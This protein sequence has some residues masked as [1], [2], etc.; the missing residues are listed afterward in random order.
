MNVFMTAL[1]WECRRILTDPA[2]RLLLIV[3][4]V[5]YGLVYPLP[6]ARQ[7]LRDVPIAVVDLAPGVLGRELV[8]MLDAH[9]L[10]R[11][12]LVTR[13]MT[14]ARRALEDEEVW[15]IVV[16]PRDLDERVARG[17]AVDL[18]TAV[19]ATYFLVYKN[20]ATATVEAVSTLSASVEVRRLAAR[21]VPL[22][23]ARVQA[24]P[25]ALDLRPAFNPVESYSA[26]VV[27]AVVIAILHQL[28]LIGIGVLEGTHAE[29]ARRG[30]RVP[31][32]PVVALCARTIPFVVLF[33]LHAAFY[34]AV[35]LPWLG[36]PVRAS[37]ATLT[38]FLLPFLLATT[39]LG[40]VLG[41]LF[42]SREAALATLFCTSMPLVFGAGFA[43]PREAMAPWLTHLMA[44]IPVGPAV[45]GT[46]RITQ[47]G[48]SLADVS[49]EWRLLWRL[50]GLFF[51]LALVCSIF[52]SRRGLR[53]KNGE[54]GRSGTSAFC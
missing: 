54:P 26:Y 19:D 32:P 35:L 48:A 36:L 23:E 53:C 22:T 25:I 38:L 2:A 17:E 15:G 39:W 1:Q 13:D 29:C 37:A 51:L 16:V 50:A 11:V 21:G 40:V 31:G 4:P 27:P 52:A 49:V 18:P 8:R 12:H 6:Y 5:L 28:L 3:A 41:T 9:R 44:W 10:T 30:A 42:R 14:A 47:A 45:S 7:V 46:I 20:V 43:W 34:V 24:M 33:F